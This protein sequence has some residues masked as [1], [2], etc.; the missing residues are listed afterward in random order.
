MRCFFPCLQS[1]LPPGSGFLFLCLTCDSWSHLFALTTVMKLLDLSLLGLGF[2][3]VR[4][5]PN[6][7]TGVGWLGLGTGEGFVPCVFV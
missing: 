3:L 1:D 5:I 7:M 2:G 6:G 4:G